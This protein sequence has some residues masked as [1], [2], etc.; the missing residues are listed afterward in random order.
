MQ[1]KQVVSDVFGGV[2]SLTKKVRKINAGR[3]SVAAKIS[4]LEICNQHGQLAFVHA[5][6]S[7]KHRVLVNRY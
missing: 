6:S 1:F 4:Q 5:K 3:F 7:R 2:A